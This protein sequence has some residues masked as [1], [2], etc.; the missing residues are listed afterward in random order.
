MALRGRCECGAVAFEIANARDT[1]T[2]CHCSQCRRTSG[3]YW[4]S[5]RADIADVTFTRDDGLSWFQSSKDARRG[6]CKNCGSSLFYQP[7]GANH[8]GIAAGSLDLPTGMT[9][10]KHIFTADAGDYYT[11]PDDAPHIPD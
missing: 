7:V 8:L 2:C 5:T 6:F 9:A 3:H 1:V 10:G 11:I 4:A